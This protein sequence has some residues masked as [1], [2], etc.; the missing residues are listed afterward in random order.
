MLTDINGDPF[1]PIFDDRN[2][3][4]IALDAIDEKADK[5]IDNYFNE[6]ESDINIKKVCSIYYGP[7]TAFIYTLFPDEIIFYLLDGDYSKFNNTFINCTD[8]EDLSDQLWNLFY[9]KN[10]DDERH[11][12]VSIEDIREAL[13]DPKTKLIQ[14]GELL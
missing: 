4:V 9:D 12:K 10:D 3:G 14:C 8:N 11:K 13:L 5:R 7:K 2:F 6:C 1:E